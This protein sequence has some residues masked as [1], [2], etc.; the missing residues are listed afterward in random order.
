LN[1][2]WRFPKYAA[3][4]GAFSFWEWHSTNMSRLTA[5]ACHF[6]HPVPV[7]SLPVLRHAFAS[8]PAAIGKHHFTARRGRVNLPTR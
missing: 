4:D 5:L 6:F 7:Y 2:S 1:Q 8:V 3:P